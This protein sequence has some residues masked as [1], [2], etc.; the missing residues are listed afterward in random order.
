M[1][2]KICDGDG[3]ANCVCRD[4]DNR[5]Y[6]IDQEGVR[7]PFE[8]GLSDIEGN[9]PHVTVILVSH[10]SKMDHEDQDL[11]DA[12]RRYETQDYTGPND[13]NLILDPLNGEDDSYTF[14]MLQAVGVAKADHGIVVF[15]S[16]TSK[17]LPDALASAARVFVDKWPENTVMRELDGRLL[18]CTKGH[19]MREI[20]ETVMP[21]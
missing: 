14:E 16:D 3:E 5:S 17:Y 11:L 4:E 10:Q 2:E 8:P 19:Y 9:P 13:L 20:Y 21:S 1:S 6:T 12:I 18:A 15:W 7:E